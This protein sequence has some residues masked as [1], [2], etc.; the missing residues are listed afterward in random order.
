MRTLTTSLG[1]PLQYANTKCVCV[2]NLHYVQLSHPH[3]H[4][5]DTFHPEFS[6]GDEL[7]VFQHSE[8]MSTTAVT[9]SDGHPQANPPVPAPR[10]AQSC[11][12][13]GSLMYGNQCL[14]SFLK[15]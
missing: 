12:D 7:C 13:A 8:S 9:P 11:I 5:R 3:H 6:A 4:L 15:R 10:L 1:V 2:N 14:V